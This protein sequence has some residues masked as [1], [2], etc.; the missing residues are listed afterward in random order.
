MGGGSSAVG[1][2]VGVCAYVSVSGRSRKVGRLSADPQGERTRG[3]SSAG[4]HLLSTRQEIEG[5]ELS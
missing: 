5:A 3:R 4:L 2:G 1:V